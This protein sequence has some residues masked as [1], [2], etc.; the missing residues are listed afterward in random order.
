MYGLSVGL[1]LLMTVVILGLISLAAKPH[2]FTRQLVSF[3]LLLTYLVY[4]FACKQ[5]FSIFNCREIDEIEFL[6]ADLSVKCASSEHR[7]AEAFAI[8]MIIVF[9]VGLPMLYFG[10]LSLNHQHLYTGEETKDEGQSHQLR[11]EEF[12][13]TPSPEM[14]FLH[15]FYREY[16]GKY[17]YW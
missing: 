15:F 2:A 6:R 8:F 16:K 1:L 14:D 11:L 9:P 13:R 4:P 7:T 12:H 10:M 3:L 17:F 5:L